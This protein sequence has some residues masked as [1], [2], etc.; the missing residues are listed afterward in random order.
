[1]IREDLKKILKRLY[2]DEEIYINYVP[3]TKLGDYST[4]L[5]IKLS[6]MLNK[7]AVIVAQDIAS[8]IKDPI[9][10]Q[11][12]VYPPGFINF[13]I[14]RDYLR[15]NL[16]DNNLKV[17]IGNKKKV[18]VEFVSVNPTGPINVVNARAAALGDSLVKLLNATGFSAT[19]EFYV[20]DTGRQ[21]ELLAE[22]VNQRMQESLGKKAEIPKDGYSGEYII[23]LAKEL[24]LKKI[25]DTQEI[26]RYTVNYFVNKQKAT[27]KRFGVEFDNWVYESE[28]CA[29]GLIKDVLE[30]LNK[31][32]LTYL[33]DNALYFRARQFGDTE[34]RVLIKSDGQNTYLLPDIA[35][36]LDKTNRGYEKL[37][38][39]LGPDHHGYIKR[40]TGGIQ[41][42]GYPC[43]ILKVLIAQEVKLKKNGKV[44]SMSKRAGVFETLDNLLEQIPRDVVRFF[45]L[46]RSSSQHLDFDIDLALKHSDENPVYYIQYAYA[47]IKSIIRFASEKG[48]EQ[49]S[50]PDLSLLKSEE[51]IALIKAILKF[52]EVLTDAVRNLEP[53]LI[54][55]YLIDLAHSFHY[56]YHHHRVV[57]EDSK[58]MTARLFL[59][60]KT[61]ETI[62]KGLEILGVSSP[63]RM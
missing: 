46:M 30:R 37:I 12:K 19:A 49:K 48:I 54:T 4:P 10:E 17:N 8:K 2:P 32:N 62:R 59:I 22:S 21:I 20:N 33:K 18:L 3:Q 51:E 53:S 29:K 15:K 36:H 26:K 24:L 1:M 16:L 28:I 55:H 11:I 35:Y 9:I 39:I 58:L 43:G 25:A 60:S 56:F 23:P 31:K 7:D 57:G 38:N 47:R 14:S 42:M 5:A 40:I 63:E 6:K 45:F 61:A 27:L 34:D 44:L 41:A 50:N 13:Q 52:P